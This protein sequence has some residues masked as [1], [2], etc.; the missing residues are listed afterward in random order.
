MILTKLLFYSK[1]TYGCIYIDYHQ[2][3]KVQSFKESSEIQLQNIII[4]YVESY[5]FTII[6]LYNK[7]ES[8]IYNYL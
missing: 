4:F 2:V 6:L 3:K 5:S 1:S 7:I 8:Y